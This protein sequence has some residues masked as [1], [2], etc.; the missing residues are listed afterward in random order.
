MS[1]LPSFQAG[2]D[3]QVLLSGEDERKIVEVKGDKPERKETCPVYYD[4]ESVKGQVKD[5]RIIIS[6]LSKVI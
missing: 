4:G 6:R 2:L 3:A 5:P 1:W